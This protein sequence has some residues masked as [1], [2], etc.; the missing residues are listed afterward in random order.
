VFAEP[1]WRLLNSRQNETLETKIKNKKRVYTKNNRGS[2]ENQ[3]LSKECPPHVHIKTQKLMFGVE[4][5]FVE[6]LPIIKYNGQK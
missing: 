1:A 3:T 2:H 6:A 5:H 4:S